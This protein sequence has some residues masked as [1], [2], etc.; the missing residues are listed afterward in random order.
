MAEKGLPGTTVT[1]RDLFFNTPARP[2]QN[3]G[4]RTASDGRRC[5]APGSACLMCRLPQDG[6]RPFATGDKGPR[7]RFKISSRMKVL[8]QD[9]P[10]R[11]R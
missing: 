7:T 10:V 4:Q 5:Y 11:R 2:A 6:G 1:V 3:Q 8:R 9:L